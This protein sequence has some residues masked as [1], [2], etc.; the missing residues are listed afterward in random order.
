VL[1]TSP[2]PVGDW[3]FLEIP[4]VDV[5]TNGVRLEKVGVA[6]DIALDREFDNNGKDLYIEE[7]LKT[8]A[9]QVG[10]KAAA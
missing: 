8:L 10:R 5:K 4:M 1:G 7:A 6:P 9:K 2:A 3:G